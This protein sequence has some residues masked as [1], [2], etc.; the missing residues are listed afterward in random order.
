MSFNALQPLRSAYLQNGNSTSS[1]SFISL[2]LALVL[3]ARERNSSAD[4]LNLYPK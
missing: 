2:A 3:L 1:F 4:I